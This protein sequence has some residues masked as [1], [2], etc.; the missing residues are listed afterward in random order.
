[1][2]KLDLRLA[3]DEEDERQRRRRRRLV[4]DKEEDERQRRLGDEEGQFV[5]DEEEERWRRLDD[6]DGGSGAGR[7]A[8]GR[9]GAEQARAHGD[10]SEAERSALV[11][12][13]AVGGVSGLRRC[14]LVRTRE[15][16]ASDA[17]N[18]T[19]SADIIV[20]AATSLASLAPSDSS[21]PHGGP[22]R[23]PPSTAA[24]SARRRLTKRGR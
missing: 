17:A 9:S 23:R 19:A 22:L 12:G 1:M 2:S 7:A 10:G 13:G 11:V 15:G 21:S 18:V 6:N 8:R 14:S 3:D 4:N 16:P 5:D 24:S 20:S